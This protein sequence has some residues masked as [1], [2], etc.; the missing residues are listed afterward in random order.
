MANG[1]TRVTLSRN[2]W[3]CD[4]MA[5][6]MADHIEWFGPVPP[7]QLTLLLVNT[8][9]DVTSISLRHT[10][11]ACVDTRRIT[12]VIITAQFWVTDVRVIGPG[13]RMYHHNPLAHYT[14][15]TMASDT[16]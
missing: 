13:Y 5:D 12:H 8:V 11:Q 1:V 15:S 10:G 14:Y 4:V 7:R 3:Q 16:A 9:L 2:I 6:V